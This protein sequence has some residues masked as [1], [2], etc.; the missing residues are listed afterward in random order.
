MP[1]SQLPG[2]GWADRSRRRTVRQ[3]TAI[4]HFRGMAVATRNIR[5]FEDTWDRRD[6]PLGR[7]VSSFRSNT[8][9]ATKSGAP[10]AAALRCRTALARSLAAALGRTSV[11][12]L[13]I[14]HR[15][16]DP[17]RGR[18]GPRVATLPSSSASTRR[19]STAPARTGAP[20]NSTEAARRPRVAFIRAAG[21]RP[22]RRGR[23]RLSRPDCRQDRELEAELRAGPRRRGVQRFSS[24]LHAAPT[25]TAA[26]AA[27]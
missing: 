12:D 22:H 14:P 21:N 8:A 19:S 6:R 11:C 9:S 7:R 4:A 18:T 20:R 23:P 1:G 26:G 17:R 16:A 5:D 25:G 24:R 15:A 27:G 3:I 13:Q 2:A 10:L